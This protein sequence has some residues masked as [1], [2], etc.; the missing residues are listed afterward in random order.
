LEKTG[1]PSRIYTSVTDIY[2]GRAWL[3]T[4]GLERNGRIGFNK[5]LA[6]ALAAFQ[7]VEAEADLESLILCEYT[8]ESQEFQYCGDEDTATKDTLTTAMEGFKDAQV[9]LKILGISESYRIAEQT[10]SRHKDCRYNGMHQQQSCCKTHSTGPV[11]GKWPACEAPSP[12]RVLT[13]QKKFC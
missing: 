3:D 8:Y 6:A 9:A 13:L 4:D 12:C 10:Y 1:L 11:T 2:N 7:E 5:G